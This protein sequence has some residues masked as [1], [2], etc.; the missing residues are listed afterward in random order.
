MEI[1]I[2]LTALYL[3]IEDLRTK[4]VNVY[5]CILLFL[6][7][8]V[9]AVYFNVNG[10]L[11][12]LLAGMLFLTFMYTS[13]MKLKKTD[14]VPAKTE[15]TSIENVSEGL[16]YLP[17]VFSGFVLYA[18]FDLENHFAAFIRNVQISVD[19]LAVPLCTCLCLVIF[20]QVIRHYLNRDK[21]VILKMGDGDIWAISA[22][23]GF[24]SVGEFF[25]IMFLANIIY[26]IFYIIR[27]FNYARRQNT[28]I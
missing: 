4:T 6:L 10:Y 9:Y 8:T 17:F 11:D 1:C 14:Y 19:F 21:L 25:I 18:L 13:T 15:Y 5:V 22:A 23:I 24:F 27:R 7:S 12:N 28:R 2:F 16:P 20:V 3:V 26:I